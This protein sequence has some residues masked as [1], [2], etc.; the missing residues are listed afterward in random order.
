MEMN[1]IK[2]HLGAF[3]SYLYRKYV[4]KKDLSGNYPVPLK[5]KTVRKVLKKNKILTTDGRCSWWYTA[6][7]GDRNSCDPISHWAM[8]YTIDNINKDSRIFATG[9]GTGWFLLFLAEKGYQNLYGSDIM[10]ECINALK[11]F[12]QIKQYNIDSWED[13][14][15]NPSRIPE[16]CDVIFVLHWIFS[17]W[18]GNYS[19]KNNGYSDMDGEY[20]LDDF[21]KKYHKSIKKGGVM[22]L[23]LIDKL[24]DYYNVDVDAYPIRHTYE[25][26][27]KVVNKY[28]FDI[29]DRCVGH[30]HKIRVVYVL[31][32]RD[33]VEH[34]KSN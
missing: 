7:V 20:L 25:T 23:E 24:S 14:G 6:Y 8:S 1:I 15:F 18:M 10:P 16:E 19:D 21:I 31:K 17:A 33:F 28:G 3:I 29:I 11:E 12:T 34:I 4:Q 30:S 32:K 5:D 26:V 27:N 9:C 22:F 2:L 13:N